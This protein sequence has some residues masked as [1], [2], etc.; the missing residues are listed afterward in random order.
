M[1]H[2]VVIDDSSS[3]VEVLS[4]LLTA[5]GVRVSSFALPEQAEDALAGLPPIDVVFCDLEMPRV[6]GY[7]LLPRLRVQLGRAVP[8]IAYTVHTSQMNKAR[9]SGFD[10]FL[11]KPIDGERGLPVWDAL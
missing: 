2:A 6:S 11:G 1:P 7:E 4:A 10:G 3:N 9:R 5:E 8:V